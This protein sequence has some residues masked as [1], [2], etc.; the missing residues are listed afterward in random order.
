MI[1]FAR[2]GVASSLLAAG[3]AAFLFGAVASGSE[4]LR[5]AAAFVSSTTVRPGLVRKITVE[6][7]PK[8]FAT[9]SVT[10]RSRI[11]P[12]PEGVLPQ[13]PPSF[14]VALFAT[15]LSTPRVIRVAPNGDV[16]VVESRAG[17]VRV[18]RG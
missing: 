2:P 13:A 17:Q 16:F 3:V 9:E 5:G 7:L 8:P 15:G 1:T 6:D 12:R 10:T 11:V 4:V 14:R 18:F